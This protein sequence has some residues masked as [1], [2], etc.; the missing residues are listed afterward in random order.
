MNRIIATLVFIATSA[1]LI[2]PVVQAQTSSFL[3]SSFQCDPLSCKE[4]TL[5]PVFVGTASVSFT[6]SCSGGAVSGLEGDTISRVGVPTAC[7]TALT[8]RASVETFRTEH[9]DDCGIPF[10]VDTV[11]QN[12]DVLDALGDVIFHKDLEA[13]CDGGTGGPIVVGEK[14][15]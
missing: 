9:L 3:F 5:L 13:S 15:C 1:V 8:P 14:P 4:Q 6:S 7:S 11:R 12:S 10:F 2:A